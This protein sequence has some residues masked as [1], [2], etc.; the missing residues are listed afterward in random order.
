MKSHENVS[1]VVEVEGVVEAGGSGKRRLVIG[2]DVEL[3]DDGTFSAQGYYKLGDI[4]GGG[5]CLHGM[6]NLLHRLHLV[7]PK[8]EALMEYWPRYHLNDMIAGSP[9]QM[10]VVRER[11]SQKLSVT[12][13]TMC[14]VLKEMGIYEDAEYP[15]KGRGYQYGEAWLK[16]E[17]PPDKLDGIKNVVSMPLTLEKVSQTD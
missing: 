7:C 9:R 12:Y 4:E 17:I 3:T 2:L 13:D 1:K 6:R 14:E 5:Q 8:L 11:Q 15:W 16:E 10:E